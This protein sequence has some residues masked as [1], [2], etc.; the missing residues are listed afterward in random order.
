MVQTLAERNA[1]SVE[2][3]IRDWEAG[4]YALSYRNAVGGWWDDLERSVLVH[5]IRPRPGMRVLDAGCG[6]GRVA[7]ALAQ[8]GCQVFGLDFSFRS[9]RFL[10]LRSSLARLEVSAVLGTLTDPLPMGDQCVDAVV[11]CQVVQH[12]PKREM[13]IRA[14]EHLARVVRPDGR[15]TA[16]VYKSWA[17][18]QDEGLF[19]KGLF[20]HRYTPTELADELRAGNWTP[21]RMVAYYRH[22]WSHLVPPGLPKAIENLAAA[23]HIVDH[24]ARYLLV[25]ARPTV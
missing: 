13:R 22:K 12:I 3:G 5:S 16:L 24:R 6:V 7:F 17:G 8:G 9:L 25:I 15:L 4:G 14:W 18:E 23:T 1:Q 20:Y 19:D 21:I 2:I 10:R 11:S